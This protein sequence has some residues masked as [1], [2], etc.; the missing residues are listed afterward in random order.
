[1]LEM[2]M[3]EVVMEMEKAAAKSPLSNQSTA[4]SRRWLQ[5]LTSST[6]QMMMIMMMMMMMN[7]RR[8]RNDLLTIPT[9]L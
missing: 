1:M 4:L 7:P 3:V 6:C 2:A 8:K 9:P 5:N